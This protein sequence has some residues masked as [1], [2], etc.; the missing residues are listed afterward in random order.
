M[1]KEHPSLR[2]NKALRKRFLMLA[3]GEQKNAHTWFLI[4]L[5]SFDTYKGAHPPKIVGD[6]ELVKAWRAHANDLI[7]IYAPRVKLP[8]G[9]LGRCEHCVKCVEL[10][11]AQF[12]AMKQKRL[13][14]AS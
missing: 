6:R 9:H 7:K 11:I 14:K 1:G 3:S 13:Q 8:C 4:R 2:V 5:I 10:A 12:E